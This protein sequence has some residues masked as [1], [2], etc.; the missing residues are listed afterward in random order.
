MVEKWLATTRELFGST[1]TD[2]TYG[3]QPGELVQALEQRLAPWT[4]QVGGGLREW[5]EAVAEDPNCRLV[6]A[7]RAAKWFQSHLRG[8]S[9]KLADAKKRFSRE[10]AA[11]LL[12]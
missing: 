11:P 8:V 4:A 3:Q 9:D 6:G 5:I 2:A 7:R 1:Q 10:T 12:V